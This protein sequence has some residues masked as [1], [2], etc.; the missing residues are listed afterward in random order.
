[1]QTPT[2]FIDLFINAIGAAYIDNADETVMEP[3]TLLYLFEFGKIYK[4]GGI[5]SPYATIEWQGVQTPQAIT[6]ILQNKGIKIALVNNDGYLHESTIY[7]YDRNPARRGLDFD[8]SPTQKADFL[9]YAVQY[10]CINPIRDI[11]KSPLP[12]LEEIA[13]DTYIYTITER[14][15]KKDAKS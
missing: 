6:S 13:H 3:T 8:E 9:R 15:T 10:N 7:F 1:M 5:A 4:F 11:T 2:D 14:H 12:P